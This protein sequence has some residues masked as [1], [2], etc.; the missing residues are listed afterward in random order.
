MTQEVCE[1]K[2]KAGAALVWER[3]LRFNPQEDFVMPRSLPRKVGLLSCVLLI[4][5]YAPAADAQFGKLKKAAEQKAVGSAANAATEAATGWRVG[6]SPVRAH[7]SRDGRV[8]GALGARRAVLLDGGIS[9]QLMIREGGEMHSWP[10][11]RRVPLG[12]VAVPRTN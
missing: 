7:H 11:W 6:E 8:M 5:A 1:Y 12:L 4:A 2:R 9:C 10:G 3:P